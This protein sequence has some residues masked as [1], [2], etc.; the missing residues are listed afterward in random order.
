MS[1]SPDDDDNDDDDDTSEMSNE[2]TDSSKEPSEK[3]DAMSEKSNSSE[4]PTHLTRSTPTP[5]ELVVFVANPVVI[6]VCLQIFA[7]GPRVTEIAGKAMSC[8]LLFNS[9]KWGSVDPYEGKTLGRLTG[10]TRAIVSN[11][12]VLA[13]DS[14]RHRW[15][16][17]S[18]LQD[19]RNW[20]WPLRER[21]RRK[22]RGS[23]N[24]VDLHDVDIHS[25][26][27]EG[28]ALV[29]LTEVLGCLGQD[30]NK[31]KRHTE[32]TQHFSQVNHRP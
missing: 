9:R 19:E 28:G 5:R 23:I 26:T 12:D 15:S 18:M 25:R 11:N 31:R 4:H 3:S 27:A 10:A 20:G 8:G 6:V 32:T 2:P 14:G 1:E 13:Q 24:G 21:R 16:A 22:G 29:L 30:K 7:A 17:Q